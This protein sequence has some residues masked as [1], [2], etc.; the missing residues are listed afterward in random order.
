MTTTD[1]QMTAERLLARLA[2]LEEARATL[3]RAYTR[4]GLAFSD[5]PQARPVDQLLAERQAPGAGAAVPVVASRDGF[6]DN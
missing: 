5:Q 1:E 3:A 6:S 2:A 4:L